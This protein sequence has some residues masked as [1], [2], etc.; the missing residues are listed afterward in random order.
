[1]QPPEDIE[2][3]IRKSDFREAAQSLEASRDTGAQLFCAMLRAAGVDVRL[4]CSLQP[5]PFQPSQPVTMDEVR[6]RSSKVAR[7]NHQ[8]GKAD[9]D[10]VDSPVASESRAKVTPKSKYS[11][12]I[13]GAR[14]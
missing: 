12:M 7:Q 8:A 14:Y 9:S 3:P 1:M 5:L 2:L 6:H 10:P 13:M 4:V 11:T